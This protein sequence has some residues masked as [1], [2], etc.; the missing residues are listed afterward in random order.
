MQADYL[1]MLQN[2]VAMQ[3]GR[4][5]SRA[6]RRKTRGRGLDGYDVYPD[7]SSP[8]VHDIYG[9]GLLGGSLLGGK[10]KKKKPMPAGLKKYFEMKKMAGRG[11]VGSGEG[12][13]RMVRGRGLVGGSAE[14]QRV[15]DDYALKGL[16]VP[17]EVLKLLRAGIVPKTAK[18]TLV[19]QVRHI[20]GKMGLGKTPK[21]ALKKYTNEA[22][23][24][25]KQ[26][27]LN[28]E[29]LLAYPPVEGAY[30]RFEEDRWEEPM[31]I[32]EKSGVPAA[33][34]ALEE[35]DWLKYRKAIK[36]DA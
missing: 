23:R 18:E 6:P 2:Q 24:A 9:S 10:K 5:K 4:R 3:G 11:L 12:G 13:R 34:K 26:I 1:Q 14:A 15:Y 29:K 20:E 19:D 16:A 25:I 36:Q 35:G 21:E 17:D 7:G 8:V 33:L 22:L 28:N 32:T 31:F 27:Y 30:D